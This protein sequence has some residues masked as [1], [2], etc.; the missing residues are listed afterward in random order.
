MIKNNG[1]IVP[2][3][4]QKDYIMV[5]NSLGGGSFGKTVLLQDPYIDELFVAKKYEPEF[6][7][8]KET[9]YKNFLDEIKIL[10]KLNHR[11]IVRV[12]NYYAYDNIFTGYILMEYVEGQNIQEY[13]SEYIDIFAEVSIDE[14][15]VQLID[16][17][18][19]IEQNGILHRDIREGNILI[20]KTGTVKIIDFG[21][22]KFFEKQEEN[23]DSLFGQIN[24]ANS[25]TLPQEYYDG[26]Y[27]SKTDMFYLAELFNRLLKSAKYSDDINFSYQNILDKMM[28]K[29]PQKRYNNFLEIREA[30]GKH[31]FLSMNISESDKTIYQSLSNLI[32]D[33][34][35]AYIDERKFNYDTNAFISRM[36]KALKDNLFEDVIQRNEDIIKCVVLS[37]YRYNNRVN[38]PCEVVKSFL[39]WFKKVTQQSQ[40]L[41]LNN[42]ISK[43]MSIRVEQSDPDLPF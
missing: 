28:Q 35:S 8:I 17:F 14:V 19:Y 43:F 24:R 33:S 23:T 39:D 30:I 34:L 16:G 5:N 25:D 21:I 18:N 7:S 37:D 32:Y 2:F 10:H 3:L 4:K 26:T 15:F 38:I 27:T 22:G 29:Q 36:E 41:I 6:E 12:Y 31:D 11:N 13:I 1:D 20:D 42:M 9:F 40:K